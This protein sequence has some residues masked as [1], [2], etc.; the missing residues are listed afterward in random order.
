MKKEQNPNNLAV[1]AT[2]LL[3]EVCARCVLAT[4]ANAFQIRYLGLNKSAGICLILFLENGAGLTAVLLEN[5][6]PGRSSSPLD[7]DEQPVLPKEEESELAALG[8][9]AHVDYICRQK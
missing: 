9:W 2:W 4:P 7:L 3:L 6:L 5:S 8:L 1:Q